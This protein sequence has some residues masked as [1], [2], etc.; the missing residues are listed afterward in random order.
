MKTLAIILPQNQ[1]RR[2]HAILAERLQK[3]GFK[4][5]ITLG[6]AKPS[7]ILDA[8]LTFERHLFRLGEN[9]LTDRLAIPESHSRKT[10]DLTIDLTEEATPQTI[11]KNHLRLG[12][13]SSLAQLAAQIASGTLPDM[14][15]TSG[16]KVIA[17]ARPMIDNRISIAR[18]LEDVLARAISLLCA[19]VEHQFISIQKP[20]LGKHHHTTTKGL[21][22]NYITRLWPR[23]LKEAVRRKSYRFAHWRV[24]YRF[25]EGPGV[26]EKT[27]LS[28]AS[29]KVLPDDG[30]HFYADPFPFNH[31]GNDY[32]FVEDYPHNT[33]KAIIS[34]SRIEDGIAGK[35]IP[36]IEEPYHLSYPQVFR[37]DGEIWML[38]ESSAG[39]KLVL[40]RAKNFPLEWERNTVLRENTHLSDATLLKHEG[41]FWLF[42]TDTEGHGSTSDM[43]VILYAKYLQ[44]PWT[45]HPS[46]PIIIDR[47]AARPGGAFIK[48]GDQ[49]SLPVQDGTLEYGGGLGLVTLTKLNKTEVTF[50]SA[51]AIEAGGNW[52]YPKIHT[53][54]R[55][56]N[57]EV[58]DGIASVKK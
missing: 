36:V 24:G 25:I 58:I 12:P 23:L 37:H 57:L 51:T 11:K 45:E 15:V 32:I 4:V 13:Y 22:L 41:L 53:L 6:N 55:F 26:A 10:P 44:G 31:A 49:I 2:W 54:N 1:T 19:A 40:Y 39:K 35:P 34:V 21:L 7:R 48:S 17:T 43:L 8:I 38:P 30:T 9:R 47:A 16:D 20:D 14:Q 29:W 27:D 3:A 28:G 46:N 50:T 42:A 5:D 33:K 18:G 52:P 56:G